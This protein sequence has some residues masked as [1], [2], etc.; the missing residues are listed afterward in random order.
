MS[1]WRGFCLSSSFVCMMSV[2]SWLV[3]TGCW[4]LMW[5]SHCWVTLWT[6]SEIYIHSALWHCWLG[7]TNGIRPVKSWLLVCWCWQFD[8][9]FTRLIAP[10]VSTTFIILRS[11]KIRNGDILLA[12]YT[13][14][15]LE[16]CLL[17]EC[18][19]HQINITDIKASVPDYIQMAV[20]TSAISTQ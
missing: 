20:L 16:K 15:V 7:G 17:N 9:S 19:R 12:A 8:W 11:S 5:L 18:P 10:V 6:T 3:L 2:V 14:V 4:R 13:L 1:I